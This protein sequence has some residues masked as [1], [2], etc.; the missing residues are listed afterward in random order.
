MSE[1]GE[2]TVPHIVGVFLNRDVIVDHFKTVADAI[3]TSQRI[4]DMLGDGRASVICKKKTGFTRQ[5]LIGPLDAAPF[6]Y[7]VKDWEVATQRFD[8]LPDVLYK[9]QTRLFV[10]VSED[11]ALL[12]A[13]ASTLYRHSGQ[14]ITQDDIRHMVEAARM[15]LRM[16]DVVIYNRNGYSEDNP[17]GIFEMVF[18]LAKG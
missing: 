14:P 2:S 12:A 13:V 18:S 1:A 4:G 5:L 17:S 7:D 9:R 10:V 15:D 3:N 8:H 6:E 11:V 16:G